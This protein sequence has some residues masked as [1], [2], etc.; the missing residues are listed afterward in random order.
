MRRTL[1]FSFLSATLGATS[2]ANILSIEDAELDTSATAGEG[3]ARGTSNAS[4]SPS[5]GGGVSPT[6]EG[7]CTAVM[8]NCTGVFAVYTTIETCLAVCPFLPEGAEGDA[9]GNSAQCRWHQATLAPSEPSFYCPAAGPG[10]NG[11]CGTNCEG[12]CE[13]ASKLC[14]GPLDPWSDASAC[15]SDCASLPDLGSYSTDPSKEMYEG[16]TVECRLFHVSAAAV[17]DA[18]AHCPHV[19]G[20]SPCDGG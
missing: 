3:A 1:A 20:K 13:L 16:P 11:V 6:C 10:G 8:A 18:N 5:A 14:T 12:L 4:G 2:C 15:A 19:G 9:T 17:D 7:Y